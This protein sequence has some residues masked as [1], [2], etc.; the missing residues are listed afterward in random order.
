MPFRNAVVVLS[1][2]LWQRCCGGDRGIVGRTLELNGRPYKVVGVASEEFRGISG[3]AD[4]WVPSMM[5]PGPDAVEIRRWRWVSVVGLLKPGVTL[6][7]AREDMSRV[8]GDLEKRYPDMNQGMGVRLVPLRDHWF[9]SLGQE[10]RTAALGAALLLLFAGAT[11]AILLRG[12]ASSGRA[13]ALTL[14]SAALGL[15]LAA[16]A[17]RALAPV[18]GFDLPRF[19]R[20]TPGAEVIAAVLGL[21]LVCGFAV[22]LASRTAGR[23]PG[24][25]LFQGAVVALEAALAVFLLVS[26]F[27]AARDY[28]ELVGQDLAFRPDNLLTL[29]IDPRGPKYKEDPPVIALVNRYLER[30]A[31]LDGVETVGMGGPAIPTDY[32][33]GGYMTVEERDN[34]ESPDGTWFVMMHAVSPDYFKAL[35]VPV[36]QG[37]TF[38]MQDEHTFGAVVS[39]ALAERNW[40]GQNPLGKRF[41]FGVRSNTI[42]PWL[43]VMGV[44]PDIRHDGYK[45]VKRPAPDVYI[46]LR[47]FQVRLPLTL[48]FLVR[49][50]E[51]VSAKSLAPAV[52]REIRAVAA[53]V[54]PYDVA[55]MQERLDRQVQM[56]H[57][58]VLLAELFA[59]AAAVLALAAAL[60]VAFGGR[61]SRLEAVSRT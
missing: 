53:D 55:T 8:T 54:P 23:G 58:R 2:G 59:G 44:V 19:V 29:R 41:K 42:R 60:G 6:D 28:R 38:T 10:L 52:E 11:A 39:K 17:V 57:L 34:K 4:L 46:P 37:R 18:S 16:W 35:G 12:R 61:P 7:E 15:G 49:A 3:K 40:P 31:K 22:G 33:A 20:L 21:A 48:N 13:M 43:T 26:G 14:L 25:R 9:G 1:H 27:H 50:R 30:L 24:W 36:L 51:G 5:P 32:W 47:E 45:G 56:D